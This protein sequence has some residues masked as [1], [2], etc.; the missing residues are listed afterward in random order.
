[1]VIPLQG[2]VDAFA[3]GQLAAA[4]EPGA[5]QQLEIPIHGGQSVPLLLATELLMEFLATQFRISLLQ[6]PQ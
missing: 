1:M 4:H 6:H 2:R 3:V 5:L